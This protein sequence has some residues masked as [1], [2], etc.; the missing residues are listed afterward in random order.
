MLKALSCTAENNVG[1]DDVFFHWIVKVIDNDCDDS[2]YTQYPMA[3]LGCDHFNQ[4][5]NWCRDNICGKYH[6][7]TTAVGFVD[8][9]D[10][11]LFFLRFG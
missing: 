11:R 7:Y 3:N 10:A 1:P 6:I 2:F 4:A 5:N 9:A 8:E